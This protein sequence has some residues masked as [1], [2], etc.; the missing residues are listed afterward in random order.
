M[1]MEQDKNRI[2]QQQEEKIRSQS[3]VFLDLLTKRGII[4]KETVDGEKLKTAQQKR[5]K[6]AYHNTELLLKNYRTFV[7]QLECRPGV[8]AEELDTPFDTIDEMIE[9]LQLEL[10]IGDR[11]REREFASIEKSRALIDRVNE[12]LTVLKKKPE[13]GRQL[14]EL[15]YLTYIAPEKLSHQELLYRLNLSSRS[16]Y[17]Q[18]EQAITVLSIRLWAA[19]TTE[20]EYMLDM[21][22]LLETT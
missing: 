2:Y 21:L 4:T 7:W 19:P 17:R 9:R 11:K 5:R 6:A 22:T 3:D 1:K 20:T 16:Y 15:I 10:V 12:A 8:I 18:R 13:N 14:Y